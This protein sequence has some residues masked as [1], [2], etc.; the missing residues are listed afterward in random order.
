M[1]MIFQSVN[2]EVWDNR[3]NLRVVAEAGP[4]RHVKGNAYGDWLITPVLW[5]D[6]RRGEVWR[7]CANFPYS[8]A[9]VR[10][11]IEEG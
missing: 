2:G 11:Y 5:S 3:G 10:M 1:K 7:W 6:G 8:W 9:E 4:S